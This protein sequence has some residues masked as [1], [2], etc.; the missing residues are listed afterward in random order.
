MCTARPPATELWRAQIEGRAATSNGTTSI[1]VDPHMDRSGCWHG[2]RRGYLGKGVPLVLPRP[3]SRGHPWRWEIDC[4]FLRQLTQLPGPQPKFWKS[5]RKRE[6]VWTTRAQPPAN[7]CLTGSAG[8]SRGRLDPRAHPSDGSRAVGDIRI[9]RCDFLKFC[10]ILVTGPPS[11]SLHCRETN[12]FPSHR[13]RAYNL[14][15]QDRGVSDVR[16]S[17]GAQ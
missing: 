14:G 8:T 12:N 1:R 4:L 15:H 16:S 6:I 11:R 3:Y 7:V 5:P 2:S 17:I 13:P 10:M 9:F